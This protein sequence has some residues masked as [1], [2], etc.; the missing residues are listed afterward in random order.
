MNGYD[1]E[2]MSYKQFL[3][4]LKSAEKLELTVRFNIDGDGNYLLMFMII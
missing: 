4:L 3:K 2:S 1:T